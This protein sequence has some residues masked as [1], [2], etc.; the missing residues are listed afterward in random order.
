MKKSTRLLFLFILTIITSS[1]NEDE[2][3]DP[4]AQGTATF[5]VSGEISQSLDY[6]E[7]EFA[8]TV[9][10]VSGGEISSF[11]LYVGNYPATKTALTISIVD[12]GNATGFDE[13]AYT[14]E[15]LTSASTS[16]ST[17]G[18]IST[19]VTET[20]AYSINPDAAEVNKLTFTKIT[21]SLIEGSF[22]LNLE[23]NIS[24]EKINLSGT[25]KAVG[26]AAKI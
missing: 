7:V 10:S 15:E 14:Y 3:M 19:Y 17:S 9:S 21:D 16:S 4:E 25:F 2:G 5:T 1:C 20:D 18:F 12:Q 11:T 6:E 24:N 23:N 8:Y 26:E 22:E 13:K